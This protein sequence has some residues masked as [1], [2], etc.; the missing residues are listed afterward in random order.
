MRCTRSPRS[1]RCTST[2]AAASASG[3]S[4]R[5]PRSRPLRAGCHAS[6]MAS[7]LLAAS[8]LLYKARILLKRMIVATTGTRA[9]R[10]P[11]GRPR[12]ADRG[13]RAR[14]ALLISTPQSRPS[15]SPVSRRSS[16]GVTRP[17]VPAPLS[18]S[19]CAVPSHCARSLVSRV[20]SRAGAVQPP[21]YNA[22]YIEA[23]A[24]EEFCINS[25]YFLIYEHILESDRSCYDTP[26]CFQLWAVRTPGHRRT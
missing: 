5:P 2:Q 14:G 12:C 23:G 8:R 20:S 17:A 15:S 18:G 21:Y 9:T 4:P 1:T 24:A 26:S 13:R 25:P 22:I 11:W 10:G 3:F 16:R 6:A 7:A 19:V